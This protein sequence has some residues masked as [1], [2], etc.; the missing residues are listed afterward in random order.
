MAKRPRYLG[1][2]VSLIYSTLCAMGYIKAPV[3]PTI[4]GRA[5]TE[6]NLYILLPLC[7]YRG[8]NMMTR[9]HYRNVAEIIRKFPHARKTLAEEF[10]EMFAEDNPRFDEERFYIACG[11]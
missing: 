1:R 9:K 10:S 7:V 8:Q 3:R 2:G 11:L 4:V 6:R 5:A